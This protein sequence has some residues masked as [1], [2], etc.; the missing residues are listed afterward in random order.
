VT[1]GGRTVV[2]LHLIQMFDYVDGRPIEF[3]VTYPSDGYWRAK[4]LPPA[5]RDDT[6]YGTSFLVGPIEHRGRPIVDIASLSIDPEARRYDMVFADGS[7]ARLSVA[8]V[9]RTRAELRVEFDRPVRDSQAF[10]GLRSM[11]VTADNADA[12]RIGWLPAAGAAWQDRP[13]A[14]GVRSEAEAIAVRLWRSLPSRH[15]TSAPEIALHGFERAI[16]AATG[17]AARN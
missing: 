17:L 3:L 6:A 12:A 16:M 4:P 7:R 11:Y 14:P 10:A 5:D 8:A 9:D 13:L 1:V 15:N 2:G